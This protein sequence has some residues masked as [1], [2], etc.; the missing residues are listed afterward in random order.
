MERTKQLL[1]PADSFVMIPDSVALAYPGCFAVVVDG[2]CLAPDVR[3]GDLLVID[4][5]ARP[6]RGDIVL[7]S[8][9]LAM[10]APHLARFVR[11]DALPIVEN[12]HC[13]VPFALN[14]GAVIGVCVHVMRR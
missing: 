4:P 3:D 14:G 12:G 1:P 8:R 2:D 13:S 10:D 7:C 5:H 6:G 9:G 11:A